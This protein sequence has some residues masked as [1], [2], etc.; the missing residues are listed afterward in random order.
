M[1]CVTKASNPPGWRETANC[2]GCD[3]GEYCVASPPLNNWVWDPVAGVHRAPTDAEIL[4]VAITARI[5]ALKAEAETY[6]DQAILPVT[7]TMLHDGVLTA[8][9]EESVREFIAAVYDEANSV[10]AAIEAVAVL[11]QVDDPAPIWPTYGA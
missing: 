2:A 7:R 1:Y 6:I 5:V 8:S 11:S 9:T 4:Q 10:I 3:S